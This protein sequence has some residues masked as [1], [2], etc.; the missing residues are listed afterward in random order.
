MHIHELFPITASSHAIPEHVH[1]D[2]EIN[3]IISGSTTYIIGSKEVN[4]DSGSILCLQGGVPHARLQDSADLS[5]W[6]MWCKQ[7][8][9]HGA[10]YAGKNHDL[11]TLCS[12][13]YKHREQ[14]R[15]SKHLYQSLAA[16]FCDSWASLAEQGPTDVHPAVAA[17]IHAL[18]CD[19]RFDS[20]EDLAAHCGLSRS[21]LSRVFH[22]QMGMTLVNFRTQCRLQRFR[23]ALQAQPQRSSLP[24]L[25]PCAQCRV[26]QL[27]SMLPGPLSIFW[28]AAEQRLMQIMEEIHTF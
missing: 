3:L 5:M 7:D 23:S 15:L 13:A 8:Q 9:F 27:R 22:Q 12:L 17:A 25:A 24:V 10:R 16:M 11:F 26:W 6:V 2:D 20:L 19:S 21:R 1:H 28:R 4:V 14:K 18:Q